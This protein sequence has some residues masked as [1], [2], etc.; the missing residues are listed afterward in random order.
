MAEPLVADEDDRIASFV[1]RAVERRTALSREDF[2]L[3]FQRQ[4]P[5]IIERAAAHTAAVSRWDP[6]YLVARAGAAALDLLSGVYDPY[7]KRRGYP[8]ARRVQTTLGEVVAALLAGDASLGYVFNNESSVL[9]TND[10]RAE[11]KVGWGDHPNPGLAAL[12]PDFELPA[13]ARAQDL[14]HAFIV[15]GGRAHA[16]PLHYDLGGEAKLLVQI[17]GRKRVVLFPPEQIGLLYFPGWFDEPATPFRVPHASDA[18]LHQ[19]DF[20]RHPELARARGVEAVLEPG[21]VL[22]WPSFWPHDVTNLDPFTLAVSCAV[23]E[24]DASCMLF[25]EQLGLLGRLF[26]RVTAEEGG[27]AAER[28]VIARAFR[29][30]EALIQSER[31]RTLSTMYGWHGAIEHY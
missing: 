14:I 28:E 30:M 6:D 29:R 1:E 12:V 27:G 3:E 10:S 26:M 13:L 11:F 15:L 9:F 7:A 20:T 19:P 24:L 17:R 22:Y 25:R 18:D 2:V 4:K 23:E 16:A 21:D 8:D 5:V 31:F